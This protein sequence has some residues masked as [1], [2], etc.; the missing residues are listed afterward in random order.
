MGSP[1]GRAVLLFASFALSACSKH[2]LDTE[3]QSGDYGLFWVDAPVER[4]LIYESEKGTIYIVDSAVFSAGANDRYIVLAQHPRDGFG[5]DASVT[6]F[7]V[8]EKLRRLTWEDRTN[9]VLG[10]LTSA[11]F[12]NLAT[13]LSLP[14]LTKVFDL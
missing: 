4:C 7:Y 2:S 3:W 9:G 8:V 5:Y 12:S 11:G 6:N 14:A 1:F 10:P 13:N